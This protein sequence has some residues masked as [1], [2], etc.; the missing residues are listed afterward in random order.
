[1]ELS[2]IEEKILNLKEFA[3]D[4]VSV[5]ALKRNTGSVLRLVC[6]YT[7]KQSA[8]TQAIKDAIVQN[9]PSNMMPSEFIHIDEI[10]DSTNH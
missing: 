1:I 7:A 8:Y 6:F 9:L 10:P 5:V 3:F 4:N 2:E